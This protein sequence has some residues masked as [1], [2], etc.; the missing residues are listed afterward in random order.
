MIYHIRFVNGKIWESTKIENVIR[1]KFCDCDR[2]SELVP[3]GHCDES[4]MVE[5][6][7]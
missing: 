7:G 1:I 6:V 2:F 3:V 5:I 4:K